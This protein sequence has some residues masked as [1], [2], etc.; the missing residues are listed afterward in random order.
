MLETVAPWLALLGCAL[1]LKNTIAP[2]RDR[3]AL[4]L[5]LAWALALM[6]LGIFNSPSLGAQVSHPRACLT[7]ERRLT[8]TDQEAQEGYFALGDGP[9][10]LMLIAMPKSDTATFLRAKVGSPVKLVIDDAGGDCR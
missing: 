6:L 8:A 1:V 10:R 5:Q 9:E 4:I 7:V 3:G 2:A